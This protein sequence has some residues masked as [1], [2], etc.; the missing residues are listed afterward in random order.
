MSENIVKNIYIS[1]NIVH[2]ICT[3]LWCKDSYNHN[4][5]VYLGLEKLQVFN[6]GSLI[7]YVTVLHLN[8]LS[9][10]YAQ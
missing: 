3:I 7:W 5:S 8:F 4:L 1:K 6:I 2:K 9:A 10:L